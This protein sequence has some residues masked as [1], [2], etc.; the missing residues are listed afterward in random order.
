VP[1]DSKLESPNQPA[2]EWRAGITDARAKPR[3]KVEVEIKIY[4]RTC[5]HFTGKTVDISE[6]G[7]A[8]LLKIEIPTGEIVQLEFTLPFGRVTVQATVRQRTAFRYGFQFVESQA[9]D[10]AIQRTCRSLAMEQSLKQAA[11]AD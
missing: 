9:E 5:G 4:T 10:A 8:A 3:F 6:S 1:G 2:R 11:G 7:I